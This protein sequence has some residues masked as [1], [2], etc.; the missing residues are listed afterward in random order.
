VNDWV[1][2]LDELP[3]SDAVKHLEHEFPAWKVFT[4]T[5][6]L[7]Y[8]RQQADETR[9][10]R[11]ES[12]SALRDELIREHW[13]SRAQEDPSRGTEAEGPGRPGGEDPSRGTEAEG[14]GRRSGRVRT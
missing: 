14:P 4:A 1:G 7:F 13:R 8:A 11:G 3:D 5:N 6:M 2:D 10:V 12:P 9:L